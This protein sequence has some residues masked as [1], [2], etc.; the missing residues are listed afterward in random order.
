MGWVLHDMREQTEAADGG[1]GGAA[2][3]G[4]GDGTSGGADGWTDDAADG[5]AGGAADGETS[6]G[7]YSQANPTETGAGAEA[8]NVIPIKGADQQEHQQ[9]QQSLVIEDDMPLLQRAFRTVA[10]H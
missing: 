3:D 2:A 6:G 8:D 9:D 5:G 7:T 1:T 10:P 4:T